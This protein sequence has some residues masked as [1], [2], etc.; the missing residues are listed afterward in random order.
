MGGEGRAIKGEEKKRRKKSCLPLV[1]IAPSFSGAPRL[2]FAAPCHTSPNRCTSAVANKRSLQQTRG[3]LDGNICNSRCYKDRHVHVVPSTFSR[4]EVADEQRTYCPERIS[5]LPASTP[6][7]PRCHVRV[8]CTR[9]TH[10]A[11]LILLQQSPPSRGRSG[12]GSFSSLV[13]SPLP[14]FL[15]ADR[16]FPPMAQRL[17]ETF[18]DFVFGR[19]VEVARCLAPRAV[20]CA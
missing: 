16:N 18:S 8:A 10:Q 6:S 14:V 2:H 17:R 4:E 15:L 11:A 12:L 5:A 7:S 3:E 19:Q 1:K 9:I 13:A 20:A